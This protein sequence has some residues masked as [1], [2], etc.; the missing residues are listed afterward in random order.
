MYMGQ[1]SLRW[2][3]LFECIILHLP[4]HFR[5]RRSRGEGSTA[6]ALFIIIAQATPD[7]VESPYFGANQI[8]TWMALSA[9][10]S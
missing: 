10:Y 3:G 7:F 4:I 9:P 2:K 8:Q 1:Y 5:G 6:A